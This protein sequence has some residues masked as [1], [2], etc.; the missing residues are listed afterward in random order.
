MHRRLVALSILCAFSCS[1]AFA[2][3]PATHAY[4]AVESTGSR[5]PAVVYGA[6]APDMDHASLTDAQVRGALRSLTHGEFDLLGESAFALGFATHNGLWGADSRAH[7]YIDPDTSQFVNGYMIERSEILSA[8]T[9]LSRGQAE[10]VLEGAVDMLICTELAPETGPMMFWGAL[11]A[12]PNGR[13]EMMAAFAGPL[14][15]AVPELT[16]GE[17]EDIVGQNSDLFMWAALIYGSQLGSPKSYLRFV[18]PLALSVYVGT[19]FPTAAAVFTRAIELCSDYE[20][21]M[22]VTIEAVQEGLAANGH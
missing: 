12:G 8:E 17:A 18:Y 22:D 3:G 20:V 11:L 13:R 21:M 5:H 1:G 9:G 10:T 4:I 19:D 7:G 2:W 14:A 16:E 15:S 6:M